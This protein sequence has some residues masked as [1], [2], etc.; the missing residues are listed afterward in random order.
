M[1]D[2]NFWRIL[3]ETYLALPDGSKLAWVLMPP[4]FALGL[5]LCFIAHMKVRLETLKARK[6]ESKAPP[7]QKALPSPANHNG[8]LDAP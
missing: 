2:T 1:E 7:G 4:G 3:S 5:Y 6:A 8:R